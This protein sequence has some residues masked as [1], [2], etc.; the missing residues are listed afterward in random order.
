MRR[1][2]LLIMVAATSLMGLGAPARADC[3]REIAA[4]RTRLAT[5]NDRAKHRELELLLAK[6][7]NDNRAGRTRLCADDLHYAAALVK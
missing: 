7:Q 3:A 6:A 5:L 4:M 1:A 2:L